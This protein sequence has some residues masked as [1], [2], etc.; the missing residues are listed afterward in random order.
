[1]QTS[2][3]TIREQCRLCS[4]KSWRHSFRDKEKKNQKNNFSQILL[5]CLAKSWKHSFRDQK[6]TSIT[7]N[8]YFFHISLDN[9][10]KTPFFS[11]LYNQYD[12]FSKLNILQDR[13]FKKPFCF[14]N[15]CYRPLFSPSKYKF[16]LFSLPYF[17]KLTTWPS[18]NTSTVFVSGA[19]PSCLCTCF[20]C[21][22][23]DNSCTD[24]YI[25]LPL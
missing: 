21:L 13:T 18:G 6:N 9:F 19:Q 10:F 23:V 14:F 11:N 20:S 3:R 7:L 22:L 12:H 24:F 15:Y 5:D 4:S 2:P 8:Q 17:L 16:L 1:M 25:L